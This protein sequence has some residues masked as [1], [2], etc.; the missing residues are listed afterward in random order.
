MSHGATTIFTKIPSVMKKISLQF[1]L[2]AFTTPHNSFAVLCCFALLV[3][4]D[5]AWRKRELDECMEPSIHFYQKFLFAEKERFIPHSSCRSRR[6]TQVRCCR[7]LP[8]ILR[9][10][11][12]SKQELHALYFLIINFFMSITILLSNRVTST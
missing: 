12:D 11:A 8:R 1:R 7:L 6:S 2:P 3:M 4:T 10:F 9:G 5:L